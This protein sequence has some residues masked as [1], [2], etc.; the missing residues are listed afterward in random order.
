MAPHGR[1]QGLNTQ[2]NFVTDHEKTRSV[3]LQT[4]IQAAY[5]GTLQKTGLTFG[6]YKLYQYNIAHIS[7]GDT[8]IAARA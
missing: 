7:K 5:F 6:V 8:P 4:L 2:V 3:F 1:T